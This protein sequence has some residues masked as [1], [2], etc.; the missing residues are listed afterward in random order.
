MEVIGISATTFTWHFF[1]VFHM[2]VYVEIPITSID[3]YLVNK[4]PDHLCISECISV[5]L[6]VCISVCLSASVS[7]LVLSCPARPRPAPPSPARWAGNHLSRSAVEWVDDFWRKLKIFMWKQVI[8]WFVFIWNDL[9][10]ILLTC[11]GLL[12]WIS[13]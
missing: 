13:I 11:R 2:T 9:E 7:C 5:S 12:S 4:H 3:S 8:Y 1:L 6:F 10:S